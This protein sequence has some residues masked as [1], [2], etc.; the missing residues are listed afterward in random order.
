[1][2]QLDLLRR[3]VETLE[4][5]EVRYAIVG[6]FASGAW[7]EPRLTND[8]DI[9][10]EVDAFAV[11]AICREFPAPE[12]YVSQSAA[13][14]AVGRGGQFNLIH[15][16]SGGKVDFM[17]I[18]G[19][20]WAS[21]QLDRCV[22]VPLLPD[23]VIAVASAEDVILGK[24]LYYREG[25]SEKHVRDITG[26]L[27]TGVVAIDRDYVDRCASEL[28]VEEEWRS[29]LDHFGEDRSDGAPR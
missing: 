9:V 13:V 4:R 24:L 17:V 16:A 25:G 28:G 27:S 26:I 18:G 1:M 3:T 29:I 14:E 20:A 10:I 7:G 22:R 2:D 6:S 11:R 21:R 12:F 23:Q 15:P 19:T 5:L 8:I